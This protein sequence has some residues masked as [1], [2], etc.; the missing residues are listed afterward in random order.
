[1][2]AGMKVVMTRVPPGDNWEFKNQTAN[3]EKLE[4]T[5]YSSLTEG[6]NAVFDATGATDFYVEARKG[7]VSIQGKDGELSVKPKSFSI[8]GDPI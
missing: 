2:A 6:L 1:M 8:Y 3:G 5:I 7:T 4:V